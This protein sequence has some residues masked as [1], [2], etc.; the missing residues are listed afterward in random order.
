VVL[1]VCAIYAQHPPERQK[2]SSFEPQ[3]PTPQG[4]ARWGFEQS[5]L[6]EDVPAPSRR[7]ELDDV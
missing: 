6:A 3:I 1:F 5:A 2:K 7:L 4:Q